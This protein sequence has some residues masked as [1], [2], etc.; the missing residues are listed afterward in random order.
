MPFL[1]QSQLWNKNYIFISNMN[2][3][4]PHHQI[5]SLKQD[6]VRLIKFSIVGTLGAGINTVFLWILTSF[7]GLFYLFSSAISIEIAIIIQFLIN[8]RWTFRERKTKHLRQFL[9]RIL[10]SNLWRSGGLVVNVGILY[11]LTEYA[12]LYYLISNIFGIICA[13][14]LNYTL[15]SRL[16]WGFRWYFLL[17]SIIN[18]CEHIGKVSLVCRTKRSIFKV[19]FENTACFIYYLNLYLIVLNSIHHTSE[20]GGFLRYVV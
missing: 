7:G 19:N 1:L 10:K 9:K 3:K 14:M 18:K 4:L 6:L 15:E 20:T 17:I 8:D 11:L 5:E 16:T 2:L 13:F 12:G